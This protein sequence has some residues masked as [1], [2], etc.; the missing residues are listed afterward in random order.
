M[1]D[2]QWLPRKILRPAGPFSYE[3]KL[4]DDQIIRRHADHIQL[5]ETDCN[6]LVTVYNEALD[7]PFPASQPPT[8]D[9]PGCCCSHRIAVLQIFSKLKGEEI[10]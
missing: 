8:A 3:I 5:S 10:W 4:S 2:S 6:T 1:T 9:N 7:D